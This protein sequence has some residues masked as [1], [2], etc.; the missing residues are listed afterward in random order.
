[1]VCHAYMYPGSAHGSPV[2]RALGE[3]KWKQL[4]L[5]CG[6]LCPHVVTDAYTAHDLSQSRFHV[7]SPKA[8]VKGLWVNRKGNGYCEYVACYAYMW[9]HT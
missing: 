5:I 7:C 2:K 8:V 4:I 3:Q 9:Q 1:M 6:V